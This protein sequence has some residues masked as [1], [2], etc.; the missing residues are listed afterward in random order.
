MKDPFI[1]FKVSWLTQTPGEEENRDEIVNQFYCLLSFLQNNN[2]LASN[3]IKSVDDL[4][5]E[6]TLL[7]TDLTEDGLSLMKASYHRWLTKVDNGMPPE[8]TTLLEK[9]LKKIRRVSA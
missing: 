4:T 6:F 7:S 8:D 9:A 5:D 3:T 2:L 1:V